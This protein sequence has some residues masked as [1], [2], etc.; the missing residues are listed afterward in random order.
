MIYYYVNINQF[1][2][3]TL[4]IFL[5]FQGNLKCGQSQIKFKFIAIML[6]K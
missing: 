3:E 6:I 2:D 4:K 1:T 5:S